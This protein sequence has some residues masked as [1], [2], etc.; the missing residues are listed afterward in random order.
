MTGMSNYPESPEVALCI[1]NAHVPLAGWDRHIRQDAGRGGKE[2]AMFVQSNGDNSRKKTITCHNCG[3]KGYLARGCCSKSGNRA[4]NK[5]MHINV[6]EED[7]DE[8]KNLLM[9][10]RSKGVVNKNYLLLDNQSAVNQFANLRLAKNIRKFNKPIT[11]HCNAGRDQDQ[12]R[13]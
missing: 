9:Q 11:V 2:G 13:R 6:E 8:G 3:K 12:T 1:L 7:P 10:Q 5:H 4:G